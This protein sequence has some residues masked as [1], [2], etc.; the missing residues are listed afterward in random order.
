MARSE[1]KYVGTWVVCINTYLDLIKWGKDGDTVYPYP[2]KS[3]ANK[4]ANWLRNQTG[5]TN[6]EYYLL[7]VYDNGQLKHEYA[8]I[9]LG[10]NS[11]KPR[12]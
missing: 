9:K 3:Q 11:E 6:E 8:N 2:T 1:P 5:V 10:A 12:R 4:Q 7:H